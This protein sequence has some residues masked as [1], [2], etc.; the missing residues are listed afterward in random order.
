MLIG[1]EARRQLPREARLQLAFLAQ[2][3]FQPAIA[4]RLL[5]RV[6]RP[7]DLRASPATD[8]EKA[9][10]ARALVSL[11]ALREAVGIFS[12][13]K[14]RRLPRVYS[15]L[16][17]AYFRQWEWEKAIPVIQESLAHPDLSS[18]EKLLAREGLGIAMLHGLGD[19]DGATGILE[20]V[21]R[22]T[23]PSR[24]RKL[25]WQALHILAQ[26]HFLQGNWPRA[27]EYVDRMEALYPGG[28]DEVSGLVARKWRSLVQL[29]RDP[30]PAAALRRLR[31]I[32]TRFLG[33]GNYEQVRSCDYYEAVARQ[34][35]PLLLRLYF[36][37][38]YP[39]LRRKL[40]RAFCRDEGS[41][42]EA[43]ELSVGEK[44][45]GP[46]ISL[47]VLNGE[48]SLGGARLRPGKLPQ[49]LLR[50]LTT[51]LYQPPNSIL[52]HQ[53]CYPGENFHP[54]ASPLRIAQGLKRLRQWLDEGG[55]PLVIRERA[56]L[57]TLK[58][59]ADLRLLIERT[60]DTGSSVGGP[61]SSR[62]QDSMDRLRKAYP[63]AAFRAS[64][65]QAL[66]QV[67]RASAVA[68]LVGLMRSGF[69]NRSG[70]SSSTKYR[71]TVAGE[72]AAVP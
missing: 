70:A 9:E 59:D 4:A 26:A 23:G 16:A 6:V 55:I 71:L 40:L 60:I 31:R 18:T 61:M 20:G 44:G 49:R 11:G 42:P 28:E 10:Y 24:F 12:G 14:A 69:V 47:R 53:D 33:I 64:D 35:E 38:P 68:L 41:I 56:G 65:V 52:L 32:R 51:D 5:H 21:L 25:H 37:S 48:N 1:R 58:S 30:A 19:F 67:S 3:A 36:G 34:S 29:H 22:E 54:T 57:Y 50:A 46:R 39:G 13:L 66:F 17:F 8:E 62:I 45:S 7:K 15:G 43:H 27:I 72:G 63:G 2:Q